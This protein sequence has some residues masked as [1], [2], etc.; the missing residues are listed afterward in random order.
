MDWLLQIIQ[1][2][3]PRTAILGAL[4]YAHFSVMQLADV[5]PADPASYLFVRL[6]IHKCLSIM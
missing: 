5:P 6:V 4:F 2:R 1:P 3:A